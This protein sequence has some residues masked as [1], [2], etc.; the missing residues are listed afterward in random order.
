MKPRRLFR[1]SL[2]FLLATGASAQGVA[3]GFTVDAVK[4]VP[5]QADAASPLSLFLQQDVPLAQPAVSP[6]EWQKID[7]VPV[8]AP[9]VAPSIPQGASPPQFPVVAAQPP[10]V[11]APPVVGE[12]IPALDPQRQPLPQ[13]HMEDVP[14]AA[15]T[16]A[17]VMPTQQL[18]KGFL[19]RPR[20]LLSVHS[21]KVSNPG[22]GG[23]KI[24]FGPD[25]ELSM[26]TDSAGNFVVEQA[27]LQK[28][29]LSIDS[30]NTLRISSSHV[31][32][33]S[34]NAQGGLSVRGVPQWQ[35]VR[36]EDFAA[37]IV[38]WS[39]WEVTEC[40]GVAMLGGFC[41]FSRGEVNK[42]FSGLP[43]H[44]QLRVVAT[45]HFID[46][47]IGETGFMKLNIGMGGCPVAVWSERYAQ[48]EAKNGLS[49][50]GDAGTPE[51]KFS[52]PID[53]TVAHQSDSVLIGFGSTMDDA[54]P[55]DESWGVST[56]EL[57]VR[58]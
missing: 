56:L 5:L 38:G 6:S 4:A 11:L 36:S 39:R 31:E 37:P 41:K 13:P 8:A 22:P 18:P 47:W 52:A 35:L 23:S 55:C 57:Y 42:T 48:Q 30:T 25:S 27:S 32:A 29:L 16:P 34:L 46:R 53:V 54:D 7:V 24:S 1:T 43:P 12:P 51:G 21:M 9:D 40:A 10:P 14:P 15:L 28:P 26:G 17:I 3:S 19:A 45:Y 58:N 44:K 50:C 2:S 20:G 33:Q 49:L